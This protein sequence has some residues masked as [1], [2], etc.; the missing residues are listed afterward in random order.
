MTIDTSDNDDMDQYDAQP[1]SLSTNDLN[2]LVK[3]NLDEVSI[4]SENFDFTNLMHH[5]EKEKLTLHR[6]ANISKANAEQL[7]TLI[8][9]GLPHPNTL[10]NNYAEILTLLS[11][12]SEKF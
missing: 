5:E 2:K 1:C 6:N 10:P 7:I 3:D 8:Q 11:G 9:S 4:V 12:P